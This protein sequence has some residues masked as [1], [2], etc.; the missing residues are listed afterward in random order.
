MTLI[1]NGTGLDL[2]ERDGLLEYNKILFK[3]LL[4]MMVIFNIQSY[5]NLILRKKVMYEK[6]FIVIQS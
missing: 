6:N 4:K 3:F 2:V 1:T 5:F